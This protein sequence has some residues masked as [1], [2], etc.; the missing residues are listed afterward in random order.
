[1]LGCIK[2]LQEANLKRSTVKLWTYVGK[3][4][5]IF[6]ASENQIYFLLHQSLNFLELLE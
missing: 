1:M 4:K 3:K 6:V 5:R 2:N